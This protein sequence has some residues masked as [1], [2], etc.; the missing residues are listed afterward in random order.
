MDRQ[1]HQQTPAS[2]RSPAG[3]ALIAA[4]IVLAI[5][6][7]Y[8]ASATTGRPRELTFTD[9]SGVIGTAGIGETDQTDNPFFHALGTN[10]RTCA[11]CHQPA[12]GWSITPVELRD[13]FERT[14]GLDPI[15][16]TNDG[17]NCK[18]ADVS[19]IKARRRAFSLL[20]GKGLI[21]IDLDVP[22]LTEW[23]LPSANLKFL[24]AVMWDGRH[25]VSGQAIGD[26]LIAQVIDAITGHAEGAR[27][28][29][30]QVHKIVGFELRLF[31]TQVADRS[32]GSLT[33]GDARSGPGS[34]A[35]EPFCIGIN[36]PLDM[37][38][39]MPGACAAAAGGLNLE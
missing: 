16:R 12:Q 23:P 26:G 18:S 20:I 29:R 38:P 22:A 4:A 17:S 36:D 13:R 21:R 2:R 27:P 37:L 39:A 19:T 7:S 28:T 1:P 3:V 31:A 15:V 35:P 25:S 34:L 5:A 33:V 10:G 8:A 6:T 24:S 11:T 9:P 14:E 30:E 32:A